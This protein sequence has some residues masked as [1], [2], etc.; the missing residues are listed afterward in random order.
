MTE[1]RILITQG[2]YATGS[3]PNL[4]ISTL[5]GS[6]V[7]VC[8]WDEQV[9]LG[10]MN[11]IL[12]ARSDDGIQTRTL[13]GLQ[14]MEVLI[15]ELLNKGARRNRLKAK[16]FGGASIID[17]LSDIGQTNI[18]FAENFLT[19]E[20]IPLTTKSFGG[21]YARNL[22]FWPATGRA[23]QKITT[24]PVKPTEVEHSAYRGQ[25]VEFF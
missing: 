22:R 2:Q 25:G 3:D 15:N 21:T 19:Q 20:R 12:L 4:V 6:C 10:G 1:K 17:G 23:L 9:G 11:H 5:L 24:T 8:L 7:A 14:A 18:E 16:A 13:S